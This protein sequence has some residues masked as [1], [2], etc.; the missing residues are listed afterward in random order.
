M[1]RL[2]RSAL[3]STVGFGLACLFVAGCRNEPSAVESPENKTPRRVVDCQEPERG[4]LDVRRDEDLVVLVHGCN[5]SIAKFQNLAMEF[6]SRGQQVGCF[7]YDDRDSLISSANE[8]NVALDALRTTLGSGQVTLIGHSQG[9]LIARQAATV[10]DQTPVQ[11]TELVTIAAPFSGVRS[12]RDCGSLPIHILTMGISVGVCQMIAGRKWT[13][14]HGD[15]PFMVTPPALSPEVQR[16]LAVVTDEKD[17]CQGRRDKQCKEDNVVFTLQEQ[18]LWYLDDA[19]VQRQVVRAGHAAIVGE[20]GRVS[21]ALI[22]V[23]EGE[24]IMSR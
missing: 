12:A 13:E 2:L 14:I 16:H 18:G 1:T 6:E 15:A 4:T 20:E 3:G 5:S 8:L 23:L 22:A 10:V 17:A 19:R 11:V 7:A 9:G 21:P 24:E